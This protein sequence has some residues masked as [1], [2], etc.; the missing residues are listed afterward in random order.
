ML[1][2][3]GFVIVLAS[4]LGG[5]MLGGGRPVVLLHVSEFVT[6]GGVAVGILVI[7]SPMSTLKGVFQKVLVALNGSAAKSSDFVDLLKMMFEL[8]TQAR[9]GGLIAIEDDIMN[10]KQSPIISKYPSFLKSS[11]RVEFLCDCLKP[12]IDGRVKPDQLGKLL[13]ADV[14]ALE[15]KSE[16]PVHVLHLIGDSLPGVGIIAAVLGIINTMAAIADGP[17]AVGERVAAALTGTFLGVLG[18]YGFVNPLAAR[19]ASNNAIQHQY[20]AAIVT[21]VSSFTGG[22]APMMA[23]ECAR[24]VLDH[25]VQPTAEALEEMLRNL[26]TAAAEKK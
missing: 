16:H 24:R 15:A 18:A 23:V 1:L 10:P 3:I 17:A 4:M 12:I 20:Y 2:L 25:S 9:R 11:E 6:I 19:I 7:A 26:G 13:Q 5:F 8:F 22:M 14:D 21:G